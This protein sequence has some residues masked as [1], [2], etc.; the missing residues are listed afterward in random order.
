[1]RIASAARAMAAL[2]LACL[3]AVIGVGERASR[4]P[5]MLMQDEALWTPRGY[6]AVRPQGYGEPYPQWTPGMYP[7]PPTQEA[8]ALAYAPEFEPYLRYKEYLEN[9]LESKMDAKRAERDEVSSY[10]CAQCV[11]CPVRMAMPQVPNDW[12]LRLRHVH[13]HHVIYSTCDMMTLTRNAS[14]N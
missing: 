6:G 1:M 8:A 13:I 5:S 9:V 4:S 11:L 3:A 2:A 12:H 7:I 10:F 14:H